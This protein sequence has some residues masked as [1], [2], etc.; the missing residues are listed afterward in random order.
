MTDEEL[1][2]LDLPRVARLSVAD[3]LA[4]DEL[5]PVSLAPPPVEG[6]VAATFVTITKDGQLRGCMGTTVAR[7]AL[8]EDVRSQ[9][10]AAAFRDPRFPAVTSDELDDLRFEVSVLGDAS[11]LDVRTWEAACAALEPHEDGVI[12]RTEAG[13]ALFLP[14]VWEKFSEAEPFLEQ[15]WKKAGLPERYFD[16]DVELQ[17]FRV[18]KFEESA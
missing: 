12:V 1:H 14:Q 4:R 5:P 10:R 16:A 9:A 8:L 13:G 11:K 7:R 2:S 3:A 6:P 17:T 15:L 18:Q